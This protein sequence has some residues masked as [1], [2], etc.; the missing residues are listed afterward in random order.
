AG[1]FF[2]I[3][4]Q[5]GEPRLGLDLGDKSDPVEVWNDLSWDHLDISDGQV[6]KIS[7]LDPIELDALEV[8]SE[9]EGEDA[10][11]VDQREEDDEIAWNADMNAAD[12]AYVLYQVPV[13]VAVHA[14]DMV[15][16]QPKN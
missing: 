7:G 1:W 3:Q 12:L 11:K 16:A 2:V 15:K 14:S 6:L 13:L 8:N 10:E 9:G 5:P 4:E